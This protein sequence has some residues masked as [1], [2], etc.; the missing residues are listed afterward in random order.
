MTKTSPVSLVSKLVIALAFTIIATGIFS[1]RVLGQSNQGG[2]N[3]TTS[4]TVANLEVKPGGKVSTKIEVK[5]NSLTKENIRVSLLRFTSNNQNGEPQLI[6]PDKNDEF[7]NWVS[8]SDK[9]FELEPNVWKKVEVTI[10]PPE[11]AA[12]GYYYAVIFDR[13]G[14]SSSQTEVANLTGSVAIPILL[15]VDAPG[16]V[17]KSNITSFK[18]NKN[19]F[20]FL[21][22]DFTVTMKNEGNTHVAPRGNIFI[23]KGGKSVGSLE[24]N[25]GKGNILPKTSREF[26]ASWAD[27]SPAY[28]LVDKDGKV[29]LK[30][31]KQKRSLSWEG[32]D[33]TKLRFGKYTA[34][35]AMVYNDGVSDVSSESQVDFW[36]I[37]WR[38]IGVST[39]VFVLVLAGVWSLLIRP[40]R[41]GIKK[42]MPTKH[43]T[44]R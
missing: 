6:E 16:A 28:K 30:D 15:D 20:E 40:V 31:G 22:A 19:M 41:K 24:V 38:I 11:T 1:T 12:F 14:S 34:K 33:L 25:Q 5:N 29:V 13:V 4:P 23:T 8:F 21:P 26:T 35:V 27:G 17:R 42:K 3:L 32:F 39:L 36:V 43:S 7:L 9:Q 37:P 44:E 10:T 18:V 2:F